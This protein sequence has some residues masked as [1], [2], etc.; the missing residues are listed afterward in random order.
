VVASLLT[1]P[2][3]S[4]LEV[5]SGSELG[6]AALLGAIERR[7]EQLAELGVRGSGQLVLLLKANSIAFFID[8]FACWRNHLTVAPLDPKLSAF[9]LQ[10]LQTLCRPI[11]LL[12]E[13][14]DTLL[15]GAAW[16]ELEQSALLLFTSGTT[17]TPKGVN[18]STQALETKLTLLRDELGPA[19][20]G[21]LCALPTHFGHGL[22]CNALPALLFGRRL[23]IAPRFDLEFLPTVPGLLREQQLGFMST[24]PAVW[25]MVEKLKLDFRATPLVRVH[26]ASAPLHAE[27]AATVLTRLPL[28]CHFF[29]VYG[30]TELAGWF[31]YRQIV[32]GERSPGRFDHWPSVERRVSADGELCVRA[33]FMFSGYFPGPAAPALDAQGFFQTGDLWAGD[34]LKGRTKELI[35]R[36]GLK[37]YPQDVERALLLTGALEDVHVCGEEHPLYGER[38]V[39][40][41]VLRPGSSL[42]ELRRALGELL[43]KSKCPEAYYLVAAVLRNSRGKVT[44]HERQL[45]RASMST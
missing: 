36:M 4:L 13:G 12:S 18:I 2:R 14:G 27:L 22:I 20:D 8:L 40:F 37:I 44:A 39:A 11:A 19:L 5:A 38:V 34:E 31:G 1:R 29:N 35:N 24:V 23:A 26:C 30:I 42:E 32:A 21:T 45:M 6:A 9:E 10:N 17:G 3:A 15:V 41:V 25:T 33:P 43:V 28:E 7:A 16:R